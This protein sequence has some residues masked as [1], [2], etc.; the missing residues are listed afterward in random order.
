M[1]LK[2]ALTILGFIL[3]WGIC[4]G[5]TD[6]LPFPFKC[7]SCK[8]SGYYIT[9]WKT[10]MASGTFGCFTEGDSTKTLINTRSP[11][12]PDHIFNW[13]WVKLSQPVKVFNI[14]PYGY[15]LV[16]EIEG[17]NPI[18]MALIPSD[19][20]A[21]RLAPYYYPLDIHLYQYGSGYFLYLQYEDG[22][23][24]MP[25]YPNRSTYEE[26]GVAKQIYQK[27][28]HREIIMK[29]LRLRLNTLYFEAEYLYYNGISGPIM[30]TV[31]M[32]HPETTY[33]T[34]WVGFPNF[35]APSAES[36]IIKLFGIIPIGKMW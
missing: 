25:I 10:L 13:D 11:F 26:Y 21:I 36:R 19:T 16:S 20:F 1:L 28:E 2:K 18:T 35:S 22:V 32:F 29:R 24:L 17:N 31:E 27:F 15:T 6:S 4:H 12:N 9:D 5:Q 14:Q 33:Y 3:G 34:P 30:E 8:Q 23:T 7:D